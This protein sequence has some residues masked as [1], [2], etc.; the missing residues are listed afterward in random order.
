MSNQPVKQ[1]KN[2]IIGNDKIH[3]NNTSISPTVL[4]QNLLK[5]NSKKLKAV[6]GDNANAFMVSLVNLY[7]CDLVGCDQQSVLNAAFIAAAL[8]LPIEKNLG[9]AYIIPYKNK[10]DGTT[11]AQFQLGYK[12]LVQLALRS[13]QIKK[14][15][16]LEIYEG[17]IKSFNPLTEEFEFDMSV[18]KIDVI[19]YAAYM[20]LVNGFNK[21]I[22]ISKEDMEKHADKF[23]QAYKNDKKYNSSKSIWSTDFDS[24]AKKTVI[25]MILK[26]A[27]LSTE[28]QLVERV[29]QA[30]IKKTD[31]D[32]TNG[33]LNINPADITY[34]DNMPEEVI[35]ATKEERE[36]ILSN[37]NMISYD[38]VKVAKEQ[39]I[40]FENLTKDDIKILQSIIDDETTKRM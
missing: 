18:P 34:V 5:E 9:F 19:G 40:D 26:Y 39:G 37:A 30:S 14:L 4:L 35:L 13:G 15:N 12:G 6:L 24:M 31:I 21:I 11:T 32:E 1:A 8:K 2:S 22:Y 23:S 27:P 25:K 17:Q 7:N 10:K 36:E 29:D 28:M 3:D 38:I 33:T 20:E 16:A